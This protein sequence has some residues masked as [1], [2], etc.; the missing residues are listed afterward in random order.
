[1]ELNYLPYIGLVFTGLVFTT[2]ALAETPRRP[3]VEEIHVV[4]SVIVHEAGGEGVDGMVAVAHVIKNRMKHGKTPYQ[5]VTAPHQFSCI[6]DR[7]LDEFQRS[8]WMGWPKQWDF[9]LDL[10]RRLFDGGKLPAASG[11]IGKA[12]H[13]CTT[14]SFP[15]WGFRMKFLGTLGSHKFY[16]EI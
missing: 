9:A 10:S 12:T 7:E 16:Q 11:D 4:A 3:G 14:R 1:M 6:N 2:M 8:G 5:V 13:Y 15:Y